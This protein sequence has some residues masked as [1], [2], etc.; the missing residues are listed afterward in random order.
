MGSQREFDVNGHKIVA[1]EYNKK[2][3]G[4][5]VVF[6][7][8]I[9]ASINFWEPLQLPV[10]K[11]KFHWISLS[12]P[13]HYPAM[14]PSG[15]KNED[16]TADMI[17][18]VLIE[19]IRDLVGEQPV[20]LV[21]H[22]TGGF[23]ALYI[24]ATY[25]DSVSGV[26][27]ISGF[28]SGKWN[29]TLGLLQHIARTAIVGRTIFKNNIK[30]L[31]SSR[32][33]YRIAA[34]FYAHNRKALYSFPGF[35]SILD[36]VY[37]DSKLLDADSLIPYFN[38]MPDIDIRERLQNISAPTLVLAGDEDPI[39]PSDQPL[40]IAKK[41]PNCKK[42][43]LHGSGHLPMFEIPEEYERAITEWIDSI[44]KIK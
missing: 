42:A 23:A 1:L 26:I 40:L 33:V 25:P 14:M 31:T 19:A 12:L 17:G 32:F 28:A 43:L 13:G 2:K 29:G 20:I 36:S 16:L 34:G 21:G 44:H 9:T 24:A 7:H 10:F 39:I 37:R 27:S 18:S 30:I 6:I 15:F 11:N 35:D 4:T 22:S 3:G 8:G 5:P 41:I 38:R